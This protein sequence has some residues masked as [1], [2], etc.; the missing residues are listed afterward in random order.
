M[1][2]IVQ[3]FIKQRVPPLMKTLHVFVHII[4]LFYACGNL[5]N[6]IITIS[7]DFNLYF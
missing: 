2:F 5:I 7:I 4:M 3:K 6:N 1:N